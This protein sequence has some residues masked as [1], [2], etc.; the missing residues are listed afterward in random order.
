MPSSPLRTL[1]LST[2]FSV[3]VLTTADVRAGTILSVDIGTATQSPFVLWNVGADGTGA[4]TTSF[5]ITDTVSVPT[6]LLSAIIGAGSDATDVNND[7][8]SLNTRSRVN[9]PA[10]SGSFTQSNLLTDRVVS[11][12]GAGLFLSLSGFVPNTTFSIQVWGYD[13]Q[14]SPSSGAKPGT[15][16]LYDRTNGA[17]SLVGSLTSVAGALPTDHNTFSVIGNFTSDQ[18]GT[19]ILESVSNI[20]GTGIMNGFVVSTI[21]EPMSMSLLAG[22]LGMPGLRCRR[23]RVS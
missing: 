6:G 14:T 16:S 4:R 13:T 7:T 19:I 1:F 10:N 8:G 21:P 22:G 3:I 20:D 18:N 23:S 11:T 17:N 5:T 9:A 2:L 12:T 15:F